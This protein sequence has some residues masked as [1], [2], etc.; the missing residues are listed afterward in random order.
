MCSSNKSICYDQLLRVDKSILRKAHI[1]R[2]PRGVSM[3][4]VLPVLSFGSPRNSRGWFPTEDAAPAPWAPAERW[5][6][7]RPAFCSTA[8]STA[9]YMGV[10]DFSNRGLLWGLTGEEGKLMMES[11][12]KTHPHGSYSSG[13]EAPQPPM[14]TRLAG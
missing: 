1:C 5:L 13:R 11:W 2:V 6:W 14:T 12:K 9:G 8:G 4:V 3:R 10:G 7:A